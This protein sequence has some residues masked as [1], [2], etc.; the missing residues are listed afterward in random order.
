MMLSIFS[1][2]CVG[3]LHFL[4]GKMSIHIFCPFIKLGFL[5]LFVVVVVVLMLSCMNCLYMWDI[6]PLSVISLANIFCHS[7]SCLLVLSV[8]SYVV[9]KL[10]HL[11]RFHLFIFAFVSFALGDS[12]KKILLQFMSKSV[13]PMFS[14]RSFMVSGLIFRYLGL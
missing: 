5:S 1:C 3:Y 7:V 13:L 9:Q 4:S 10:L 14:S 8:I 12:S 11:I 6:N 2:V